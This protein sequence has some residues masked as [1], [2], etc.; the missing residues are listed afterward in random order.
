MF[1]KFPKP[2]NNF[3]GW[4]ASCKYNNNDN[5][6]RCAN[7]F[8]FS[9]LCGLQAVAI[10]IN[11]QV[12]DDSK[13]FMIPQ[14]L[15][16]G[17]IK[18]SVFL[19]MASGFGV[20]GKGL[21]KSGLILPKELIKKYDL[22]SVKKAGDFA[23]IVLN[24]VPKKTE[25]ARNFASFCEKTATQFGHPNA[26]SLRKETGELLKTFHSGMGTAT[27]I[28]GMIV[29]LSIVAPPIRNWVAKEFQHKM[30]ENEL[31]K[32]ELTKN[33]AASSFNILENSS[34]VLHPLVA[35][36]KTPQDPLLNTNLVPRPLLNTGTVQKESIQLKT[37][38]QRPFQMFNI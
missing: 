34:N 30:K 5:F 38:M 24:E 12:P 9:L 20:I 13:K 11:N 7:A 4:M 32:K 33:P 31:L 23:K 36:F 29:G 10:K 35:T 2:V 25:D 8:S 19:L 37:P 21:V 16:E 15:I 6:L 26:E 3:L 28:L 14:E 27:N 18:I 22:S 1:E 17:V